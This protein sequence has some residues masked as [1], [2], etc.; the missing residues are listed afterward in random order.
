MNDQN[1]LLTTTKAA[2]YLNVARQTIASAAKR[3]E[4]GKQHPA[5]G[6]RDGWI[7]MF[8]HDELDAWSKR[9]RHAGGRPKRGADVT[10]PA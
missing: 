4:I 6:T 5:P 8:T 3:G 10:S 7:Y 9:V 2:A 1:E